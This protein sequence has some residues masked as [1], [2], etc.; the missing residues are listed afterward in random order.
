MGAEGGWAEGLGSAGQ[1][2]EEEEEQE[3]AAPDLRK[4]GR[5]EGVYVV[6]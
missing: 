3:T 2:E 4:K 1:V 6:T 5:G